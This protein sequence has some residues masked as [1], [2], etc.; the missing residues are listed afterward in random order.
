[1][2]RRLF[3]MCL[4]LLSILGVPSHLT[5]AS[6]AEVFPFKVHEQQLP[7]GLKI[8]VVP[9]GFPKI[10]SIQIPVQTGSRNE[11][12]AGKT[13]FAHFFEHM[14][15]RG[16]KNMSAEA[17]QAR[18]TA[19][20]AR[21][22]AYTSGDYTNYHTTLAKEDL[23]ELLK[24]EADR[25]MNLSYGESEFKTEARAVL[26]EYNK[27]SAQPSTKLW[28]LTKDKAFQAHTYKHTTLGFIQ[29]IEDMPN[30]YAYSKT[31]FDRW[32][33]PEYTS[34]IIAGD[35]NPEQVFATVRKYFTPWKRGSFTVRI[36]EEPEAKGPVYVHVPWPTPTP[37]ELAVSFHG[38]AFLPESKDFAALSLLLDLNFGETSPLYQRLVLQDH[39][40]EDMSAGGERSKDPDLFA[41]EVEVRDPK[42]T[43]KVRDLLLKTFVE[44]SEQPIDQE[45]L[46]AVRAHLR[47]Q[48]ARSLDHTESIAALLASFTHYERRADTIARTFKT[49]DA[50]TPADI[51]ATARKVIRDHNL[52]I[53]TL[54]HTPLA[55]EL[56]TTPK[57]ESFK[58]LKQVATFKTIVQEN[59]LPF[60]NIKLMFHAGSAFD[61]PGKEGLAALSAAMVTDASSQSYRLEDQQKA[62][63]PVAASFTPQ[64]DK[65]LSTFTLRTPKDK[66]PEVLTIALSNLLTPGLR[67]DDFERLKHAQ[68]TA[69]TQKLRANNEEELAKERLQELVYAGSPYAHTSLGTV[70]GIQAITL[71]DVKDFLQRSFTQSNLTLGINGPASKALITSVQEALQALPQGQAVKLGSIKALPLKGLK[72]E[73]IQK[74]SRATSI[75]FGLPLAV[76]RSHPDFAALWLARAWLG[77]HRSS[78]SHLYQRIR[79]IRG[80]NYGDYA[81][82]E[83]FPGGMYQF[84]PPTNVARQAQLFEIWLRPVVPENAPMALR[85]ALHELRQL[86]SQGLSEEDFKSTRDYLLKNIYV[87]TATQD[88]QLGYALDSEFYQQGAFT[89]VMQ[90][91]LQSLTREKVNQALRKHWSGE[92][93]QI[94]AVTQDAE[95][96]RKI[97]LEDKPSTIRY[98]GEKPKELLDEDALIGALRLHIKAGDIQITPV[99]NIFAGTSGSST[100]SKK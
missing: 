27:G 38:P 12:E 82:I 85:I 51:L 90:K 78:M 16:T 45:R 29:D 11:V 68:L 39:L 79:E 2:I 23:D 97:L 31:F 70:A 13:G 50:I 20:G 35:V 7:N 73:I 58:P 37:T 95:T 22:N 42:D 32:Y 46:N 44:A 59:Q 87:M 84:F 30:Q 62:F 66:A 54:S 52:V 65:E 88:Q 98:D 5:A 24:M 25:F 48:M 77:E 76:N 69:L 57:L 64:V 4:A 74:T 19:M 49:L 67:E 55:D 91:E 28:E 94:V 3:T 89:Q 53:S 18:L 21:Q 8:F 26:G 92:D 41:V 47:N 43:L 83:A 81:Y 61:P 34:I 56:K 99:D 93:L 40:L 1:M 6:S 17:Y 80:M 72:V 33:R 75:S 9:T 100:P 63:Y 86:I 71:Q 10:V 36:P 15:F 14:M 96:L 60:L